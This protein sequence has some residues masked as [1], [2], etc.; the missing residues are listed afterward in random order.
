MAL[1]TNEMDKKKMEKGIK[2]LTGLAEKDFVGGEKAHADYIDLCVA[3]G[4]KPVEIEPN[5]QCE[6]CRRIP[7]GAELLFALEIPQ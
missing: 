5:C 7:N 3:A 1:A 2:T 4:V 6:H